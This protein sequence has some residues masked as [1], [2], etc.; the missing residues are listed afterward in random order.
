MTYVD[1]AHGTA[2]EH[3]NP[4]LEATETAP[5]TVEEAVRD[6]DELHDRAQAA[7]PDAVDGD[8]VTIPEE[9]ADDLAD[10]EVVRFTGYYRLDLAQ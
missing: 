8:G 9:V 4:I 1:T 7:L 6:Y 2:G 5:T 3:M 10:G